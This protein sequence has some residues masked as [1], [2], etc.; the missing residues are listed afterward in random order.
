MILLP[1]IIL[2]FFISTLLT[3]C[4]VILSPLYISSN[5]MLLSTC[6]AGGKWTLQILLAYF[7]LKDKKWLYIKNLAGVCLIGSI[8]LIPN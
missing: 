5:Q 8:V 2:Y 4:F 3:W 6:I 7:I 1:K